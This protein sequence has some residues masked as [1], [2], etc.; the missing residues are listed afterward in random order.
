MAYSG[1]I[2]IWDA[3][4]KNN[5]VHRKITCLKRKSFEPNLHF[6]VPASFDTTGV[7]ILPTQTMH[8]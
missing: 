1:M 8:Y 3:P 2:T 5:M 7:Y 4:R 6:G